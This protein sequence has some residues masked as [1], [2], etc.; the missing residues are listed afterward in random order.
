MHTFRC[1]RCAAVSYSATSLDRLSAGDRCMHCGGGLAATARAPEFRA[2][3]GGGEQA[4]GRYPLRPGA[5]S[6]AG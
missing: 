3:R 6:S 2:S 5:R 1:T 4:S